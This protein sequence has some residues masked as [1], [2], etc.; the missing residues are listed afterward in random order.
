MAH[1]C[2]SP[3][4]S[5]PASCRC[6]LLQP[7]EEGEHL[8]PG[9]RAA[10][11]GRP[12][13]GRPARGSRAPSWSGRAGGPRGRA[14]CPRATIWRGPRPASERALE[15]D[16]T[17]AEGQEPGDRA[18]GRR[19]ARAVGADQGDAL[20]RAH[21]ERHRADR[22]HV[23]VARLD[24]LK[25]QHVHPP[26]RRHTPRPG[27]PR[28]PA[29]R[30]R[31][32]AGGPSAIISPLVQHDD[33]PGERHDRAHDVLDQQDRDAAG[34][35]RPDR[36]RR[37]TPISVGVRPAITSSSSRSRGSVARARASSSRLRSASV[38]P[39]RG[40]SARSSS[41]T[42]SRTARAAPGGGP[43][44]PRPSQRA[45]RARSRAR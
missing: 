6:A 10:R 45:H 19:L 43:E 3:P 15:H 14:R 32:L 16:P 44:R 36:A 34:V 42:R 39:R 1:I 4:E 11:P 22:D 17:A 7:R 30:G 33:A 24:P 13:C 18:E 38:R 25:R 37:S 5:V 35:D 2:C 28:P 31:S 41:P 12:A 40:R 21:L 20:A 23:A 27:R 8:A 29:G 9:S 26:S